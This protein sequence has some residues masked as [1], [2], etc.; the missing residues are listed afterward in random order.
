MTP[1]FDGLSWSLQALIEIGYYISKYTNVAAVFCFPFLFITF[2]TLKLM[3]STG[4]YIYQ[5]FVHTVGYRHNQHLKVQEHLEFYPGFLYRV[6]LGIHSSMASTFFC[7][8]LTRLL[9][10]SS[11]IDVH[12]KESHSHA[13]VK[14]HASL[15][16]LSYALFVSSY[17]TGSYMHTWDVKK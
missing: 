8:H 13:S 15:I 7:C 16:R 1:S 12:R 14:S 5:L 10:T 9:L 11:H 2:C 6:S 3:M 4:V 17:D